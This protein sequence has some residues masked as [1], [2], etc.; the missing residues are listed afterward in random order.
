MSFIRPDAQAALWRWREV[1]T[2]AGA[3]LLGLWLALGPGLLMGWLGLALVLGGA[4]LAIA[5]WQRGRFRGASGGLG[6]V[7][8]SEG[9]ITYFGPLTG[10]AADLGDIDEL[11]LVRRSMPMH[12]QIV[13]GAETL[14]IPVNASGAD[15]LFDAFVTL[16]GFATER[17]LAALN[18]TESRQDTLLWQR[19][20]AFQLH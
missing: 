16:P 3:I 17:M 2:G 1:L 7:E 14:W 13:A 10:G 19:R 9:R 6:H 5:G 11:R 15:A 20:P 4:A 18:A 8:I 12:W